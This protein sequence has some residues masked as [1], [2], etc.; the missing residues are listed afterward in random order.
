MEQTAA[1]VCETIRSYVATRLTACGFTIS[2]TF[3]GAGLIAWDD[4]CGMLVVVPERIFR[5]AVWPIEGPDPQGCYEGQVAI[6]LTVLWLA[7]MPTVDDRGRPPAVAAM[8]KAYNEFLA[9]AAVI[10][11]SLAAL[12]FDWEA[13]GLNQ[14]FLGTEGGCIGVESRLTVGVDEELWCVSTCPPEGE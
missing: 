12:P 10:W 8:S 7:C 11:N 1:S 9:A 4:C 2:S 14:T 3:V 5:S 6:Q 13:T